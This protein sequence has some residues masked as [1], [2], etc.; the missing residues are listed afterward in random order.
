MFVIIDVSSLAKRVAS[1]FC[2]LFCAAISFSC[3]FCAAICLLP[4]TSTDVRSRWHFTSMLGLVVGVEDVEGVGGKNISSTGTFHDTPET[5]LLD[6]VSLRILSIPFNSAAIESSWR[7]PCSSSYATT[8][9]RLVS[10]GISS[11]RDNWM[12]IS[13]MTSVFWDLFIVGI[14][15][16]VRWWDFVGN[17]VHVFNGFRHMWFLVILI[18]VW[19]QRP[20][21]WHRRLESHCWNGVW[22]EGIHLCCGK[23]ADHVPPSNRLV[24]RLRKDAGPWLLVD[25][26]CWVLKHGVGAQSV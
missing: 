9:G 5:W 24:V 14:E 19:Q 22:V 10:V 11:G 7:P 6:L 4:R 12:D 21:G 1:F 20:V 17:D 26:V 23:P 3:F 8:S 18:L 2:F 16:W 25:H 15:L 13:C